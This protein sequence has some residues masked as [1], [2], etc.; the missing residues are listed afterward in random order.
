MKKVKDIRKLLGPWKDPNTKNN[1][2]KDHSHIKDKSQIVGLKYLDRNFYIRQKWHILHTYTPEIILNEN[3]LKILDIGPGSGNILE[4][5][6]FYAHEAI[7]IDRN[8]KY[9]A[10]LNSQ[11][12]TL[13]IHNANDLPY[14]FEDEQFDYVYSWA[15]ITYLDTDRVHEVFNEIERVSRLGIMVGVDAKN[16]FFKKAMK[17]RKSKKFKL[18]ILSGNVYKWSLK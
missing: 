11:K 12:L 5:F 8:D 18:E 3:K 17:D 15:S 9:R 16:K 4:V 1:F 7:G 13:K 2:Y 14:P 6:E 10:M